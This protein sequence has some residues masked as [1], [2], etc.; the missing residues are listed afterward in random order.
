MIG[1][2]LL[3]II[4]ALLLAAAQHCAAAL[5]APG[6]PGAPNDPRYC[7]E[8]TRDKNGRIT[9]SSKAR[10]D[11]AKIW[12]CPATHKHVPS[13]KNWQIDHV[14]PRASGGCDS[15]MNM[16]WLHDSIK[17]RRDNCDVPTK[18]CWERSV[19]ALPRK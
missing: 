6:T 3:L 7:G 11:F 19:Y 2:L 9:R 15:V 1:R 10:S 4:A 12:A 18:D 8:P 14:V 5:P 17:L 13:C 16:Q